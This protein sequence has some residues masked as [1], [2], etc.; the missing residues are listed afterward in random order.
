M[1]ASSDTILDRR[2]APRSKASLDCRF[3][4]NGREYEAGIRNISLLGAFLWSSFLPP[5][6]ATISIRLETTLVEESPLIWEGIVVRH[7][8]QYVEQDIAGA[9]G[10]AL[11][12]NSQGLIE[13]VDKL[14]D[15]QD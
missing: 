5:C 13:L 3:T 15:L 11:N 8:R 4:F 2:A 7:D 9:F 12:P 6:H 10:I 14:T 1:T